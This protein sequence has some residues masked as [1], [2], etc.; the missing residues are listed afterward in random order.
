MDMRQ[1]VDGGLAVAIV[2]GLVLAAACTRGPAPD[3]PPPPVGADWD[4]FELAGRPP[5]EGT[6]ITIAFSQAEVTG[7]AGCNHYFGR[8]SLD[9]SALSIS[10]VG[11]TGMWCQGRMEQEQ[12]FLQLLT[13]A[14]SLKVE[15]D[16]LT[17]ETAGGALRFRPAGQAALEQTA[18][19]LSGLA[20]GD[21]VVSTWLDSEITARFEAGRLSGSAGCNTYTADYRVAGETLTL[22]ALVQ[23]KMACGS[24]R[25]QRESAFLAAMQRVTSL[26]IRRSTL[27]LLDS[28][29]RGLLMFQAPSAAGQ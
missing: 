29:G 24:E 14:R 28:A 3:K 1:A 2:L 20:E 10:Q 21:A 23:T 8:Y 6:L 5:L 19:T 11:Q 18:W 17:I 4:L 26:S 9:G 15:H 12:Q 16:Q 7:S 22:G 13:A 25:D 27:T